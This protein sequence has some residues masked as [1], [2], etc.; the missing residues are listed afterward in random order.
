MVVIIAVGI[1][2]GV[3]CRPVDAVTADQACGRLAAFER[4]DLG[5]E[6]EAGADLFKKVDRPA[7]G[8]GVSSQHQVISPFI[9]S[10][11]GNNAGVPGM[12]PVT[13]PAS[14]ARPA[15]ALKVVPGDCFP[16]IADC[17][18]RRQAVD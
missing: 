4:A 10:V 12:G 3:G 15:P 8:A 2:P 1:S 11:G 16:A 14:A 5:T 6:A 17:Y 7:N 18:V 9:G 13:Q